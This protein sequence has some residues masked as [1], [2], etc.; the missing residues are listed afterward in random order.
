MKK[1]RKREMVK[2]DYR[3]KY[4]FFFA[5]LGRRRGALKEKFSGKGKWAYS[6]VHIQCGVRDVI[7]QGKVWERGRGSKSNINLSNHTFNNSFRLSYLIFKDKK[8]Y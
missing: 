8:L 5:P 6:R 1:H 2:S 4:F 7:S 3:E